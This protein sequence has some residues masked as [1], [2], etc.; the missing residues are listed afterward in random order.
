[1]AHIASCRKALSMWR[2]QNN[3]N[4]EKDVEEL[5]EKVDAMYA[6]DNVTTEELTSALKELS[7]AL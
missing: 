7:D 2:R 5:K 4:S 1:M 6:D 3:L